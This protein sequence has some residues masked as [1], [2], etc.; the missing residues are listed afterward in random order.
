MAAEIH[1]EDE[2]AKSCVS[3][4]LLLL[5]TRPERR[6]KVERRQRTLSSL[7]LHLFSIDIVNSNLS[8]QVRTENDHANETCEACLCAKQSVHNHCSL[9]LSL[10]DILCS[11]LNL[12]KAAAAV[13]DNKNI[14]RQG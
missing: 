10:P 7:S 1:L 11:N 5:T 14:A 6:T 8:G 13:A 4:S 2:A 9:S 12:L 3:S